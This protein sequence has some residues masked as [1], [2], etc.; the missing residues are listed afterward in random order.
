MK[1]DL[2]VI[3]APSSFYVTDVW[4]HE[5]LKGH[6]LNSIRRMGVHSI[7]EPSQSLCNTDWHLFPN[8]SRP[9]WSVVADGCFSHINAVCNF[10]GYKSAR[11][12]NYWFQQYGPGDFHSWHGHKNVMFSS[13]YFVDL[14]KKELSTTFKFGNTEFQVDV[15]EGQILTF[16]SFYLHMSK[17]NNTEQIKTIVAFNSNMSMDIEGR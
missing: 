16:P 1:L 4:R 17:P 10:L 8:V 14:P 11:I 12:E 13:V 3:D 15:T 7:I 6:I 5:T 9:Y 2:H